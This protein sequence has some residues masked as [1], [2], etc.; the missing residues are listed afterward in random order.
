MN[1]LDLPEDTKKLLNDLNENIKQLSKEYSSSKDLKKL[2]L[3]KVHDIKWYS[4]KPKVHELCDEI[5]ALLH[6]QED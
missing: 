1:D 5:I 6:H 2:I 3:D 4:T